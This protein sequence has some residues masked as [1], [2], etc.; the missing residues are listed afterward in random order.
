MRTT[1]VVALASILLTAMLSLFGACAPATESPVSEESPAAESNRWLELLSVLPANENTLKGAYLQD[2]AL[3]EEKTDQF[4]SLRYPVTINM[5][6]FGS[7]PN[8]YS[9]E[10]WQRTLGFTQ[11]DVEQTVYVPVPPPRLYQAVRGRFS[12]DDIDSA[13]HAGPMNEMLEVVSHGGR[14]Y[15]RWGED[16]G[17]NVTMRSGVRP[18][19]RGHRLALVDDFIFWVLWTDGIQEMIDAHDGTIKPLADIE[20]YRSLA[21]ALAEMDTV[22]AFFS[23]ESQSQSRVQEVYED[24]IDDPAN[25]ERRQTLVEEIQRPL[26]L[27]PYQAM[28]TGAGIDDKGYFMAIVLMNPSEVVAR[29][30]TALLEE[31]LGEAKN[32]AAMREWSGL[33]ESMEIE[34]DGRLTLARLYGEACT[35]WA[36]FQVTGERPYEPLLLHE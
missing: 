13:V 23:S 20:D 27:K 9:D 14:E 1:R 16:F 32:V 4:S 10:E 22:T 25:N 21:G 26:L 33:I 6:L 17:I 34:V 7:G 5:P 35:Y 11:G 28:A 36:S 19:G 31:R 30:N 15:Y 12:Q 18:L 2:L 3:L 8:D 24:I 29:D